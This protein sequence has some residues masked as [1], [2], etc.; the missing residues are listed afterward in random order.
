MLMKWHWR[1]TQEEDAGLWKKYKDD[2]SWNLNL[3]RNLLDWEFEQLLNLLKSLENCIINIQCNDKLKWNFNSKGLYTV[4]AGYEHLNSNKMMI[5]LW[6]WKL[7][8][9]TKLPPKSRVLL[10]QP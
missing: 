8:W 5:D 6:P 10:G 3:R 9:K 4:K 7:V 1:F 2:N